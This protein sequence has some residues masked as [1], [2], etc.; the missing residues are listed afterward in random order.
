MQFVRSFLVALVASVLANLALLFAIGPM[1]I[2]PA[3]PLHALALGPVAVFSIM[4]SV[5]ATI[6][7]AL[8]RHFMANPQ[9]PFIW[10]SIVV[11]LVSFIPDFLVIGKTTGPFAGGTVGTAL[12][13]MLMHVVAAGIIVYV[14]VHMWGNKTIVPAAE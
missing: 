2:N 3:L 14:F 4:G 5:G 10:L 8:M 6:V 12:L 7:Y 9:K 1:V 11:L 13:L